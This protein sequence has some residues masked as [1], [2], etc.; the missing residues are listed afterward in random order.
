MSRMSANGQLNPYGYW[1]CEN[2]R[3][4]FLHEPKEYF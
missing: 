1:L 2:N 3:I 4:Y